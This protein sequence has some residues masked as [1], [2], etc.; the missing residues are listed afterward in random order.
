M[1]DRKC[2]VKAGRQIYFGGLPF[3]SIN[4]EGHTSP[5]DADEITHRIAR[6]L[7]EEGLSVNVKEIKGPCQERSDKIP[8]Y[9]TTPTVGQCEKRSGHKGKHSTLY[10]G[11][12]LFW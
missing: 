9:S 2:T 5:R 10:H 11:K 6:L 1:A 8:F 3:I 4:K 12:T 7:N